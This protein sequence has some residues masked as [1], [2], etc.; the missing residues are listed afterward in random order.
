M[1][2]RS[3]LVL[4]V[5]HLGGKSDGAK[6][7]YREEWF[8]L[9]LKFMI[10]ML[11]IVRGILSILGISLLLAKLG[12]ANSL[13]IVYPDHEYQAYS[14][15]KGYFYGS[16]KDLPRSLIWYKISALSG[17]VRAQTMLAMMYEQGI[18]T[19]VNLSEAR[20]WFYLAAL[21]QNSYAM[22]KLGYYYELGIGG[23]P[24]SIEQSVFWWKKAAK[25]GHRDAKIALSQIY[26]DGLYDIPIN[27]QLAIYGLT[28]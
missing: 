3:S 12:F 21:Q 10:I 15:A 13:G 5:A 25:Q 8:L 28:K 20:E 9:G 17:D 27:T 23:L 19:Q 24:Y 11:L 26:L 7:Y 18:G 16:K 22:N 1:R 14:Q 4:L 6:V 2:E